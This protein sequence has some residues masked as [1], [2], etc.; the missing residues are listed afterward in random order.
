MVC[1]TFRSF[2]FLLFFCPVMVCAQDLER[3]GKSTRLS[4]GCLAL[5]WEEILFLAEKHTEGAKKCLQ[6]F[7][8]QKQEG[9]ET[10]LAAAIFSEWDI[11]LEEQI[12]L[13]D[14]RPLGPSSD[15]GKLPEVRA[16]ISTVRPYMVVFEVCVDQNGK[17]ISARVLR[18]FS[19]K[20][21]KAFEKC[22]I[23]SALRRQY[24]PAR[25]GR[26]FI[27][28]CYLFAIRWDYW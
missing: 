3:V 14:P 23:T 10:L 9:D 24:R 1:T 27:T 18:R 4:R 26:Y 6:R 21:L 11:N 16:E 5:T 28:K 12:D 25:K 20:P 13:Q 19:P 7:L 15:C 22:E 8:E 17:A 2:S